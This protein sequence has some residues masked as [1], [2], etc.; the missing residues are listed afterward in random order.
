M[1]AEGYEQSD[2]MK[3][4]IGGSVWSAEAGYKCPLVCLWSWHKKREKKEF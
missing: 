1:W 3:K 2:V 4:P